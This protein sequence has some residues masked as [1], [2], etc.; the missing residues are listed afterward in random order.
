[1]TRFGWDFHPPGRSRGA[2]SAS[3]TLGV[4]EAVARVLERTLADPRVRLF[5]NVTYG[6]D[7][8]HLDLKRLYDQIVYAFG[9]Q[10]DRRMSI[11]GE[12]LPNSHPGHLVRRLVQRPS[13]LPRPGCRPLRRAGGRGWQR[14]R[15]R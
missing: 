10:A 11:P 15:G 12:N 2:R 4:G 5:G 8:H 9:A 7:L 6:V 3:Q 14:Q 1:M 13:R